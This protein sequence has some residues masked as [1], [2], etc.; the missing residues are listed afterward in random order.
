MV[1]TET[2]T[3]AKVVVSR[4]L[5]VTDALKE[6][7]TKSKKRGF[8]QSIDLVINLQDIDL[9]R[10]ENRFTEE[11]QLQAGRGKQAVIGVI[12][13]NFAIKTKALEGVQTIDEA[14]LS[15]I[16]QDKKVMRKI[17]SNCDFFIAEATLMLRI[18]KSLGKILGPKGKMPKPLPPSADPKGLV[19]QLKRTVRLKA[20]ESAVL[21]CTVGIESMK[22]EEILKNFGAIMQALEK[23]LPKGK[24][25]M[26]SIY[27]KSTMGPPIKI[28]Y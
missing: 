3:A 22:D 24:Q 2:K 13:N 9:K 12:G 5:D 21:H 18:G 8:T 1:D 4:G 25:N 28:K 6:L 16:E 17:V 7:H 15:E 19:E 11:V 10:P 27:I 20:T 14:K 26:R 23:R